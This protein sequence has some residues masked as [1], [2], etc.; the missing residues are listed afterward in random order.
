MTEE[1]QESSCC[2]RFSHIEMGENP[3]PCDEKKALYFGGFSLLAPSSKLHSN[4]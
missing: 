4:N 2:A 1:D 3:K